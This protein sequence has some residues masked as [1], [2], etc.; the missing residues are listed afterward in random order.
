[1]KQFTLTDRTVRVC[2]THNFT[3]KKRLKIKMN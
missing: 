3:E 1:V 2:I